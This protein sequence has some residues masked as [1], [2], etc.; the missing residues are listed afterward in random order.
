VTQL[1][2][3][4]DKTLPLAPASVKRFGYDRAKLRPRIVHLGLGAFF[5]A[6]GALYTEDAAPGGDWGILG[7]SL[8][9]PDQRDR[10]APQDWLYTTTETGP[11][12]RRTRIVGCL[13]GV[14]VAPEDP[15]ALLRRMSAGE[16][17]LVTLTIT[18]KGYCH[19]PASGRLNFAHPDIVHDL[20]DADAP[21]SAVGLITAALARRHAAGQAPFTVLTCDNLPRNGHLLAGLVREFAAARDARLAS[22]IAEAVPF[23]SCMVDRIVPAEAADDAQL[24]GRETGLHDAAPVTHE[25]FRQWVLED[26]FGGERPRWEEAGAQFV[27]DVQPFEHAKL[28]MLNGTHSALAYLGYLAGHRFICDAVADEAFAR[29][30]RRL[31]QAEIIPTLVAPPGMDLGAYAGTLLARYANPAIRHRTWQIAMDGSQKLPQRLLATVRDALRL[32]SP[33]TCL[34][35]AIA[36][37]MRYVGGTDEAGKPIDV[38]D[39][40][41]A[42]LRQQL[43]AAGHSPA[44]RVRSLLAVETV[45][46]ADL[47]NAPGFVTAVTDAYAAIARLGAR[48]ALLALTAA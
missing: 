28:R 33:L 31:W 16:T 29:F 23:P 24:I 21:R 36:G 5:R 27:A 14:V 7:A 8:Q 2:R 18:E 25:P 44:D 11:A 38:R 17:A 46:G 9:R 37:W 6:H 32:E 3:L 47:R 10:L 42:Q 22:W 30:L 13:T 19:D 45:F 1:P 15:A 48:Q 43:E 35:Y 4:S 39:P 26:R 12:G 40:L 41:A 20:A 34:A